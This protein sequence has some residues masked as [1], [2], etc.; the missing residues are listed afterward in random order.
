MYNW[1]HIDEEAMKKENPEKYRLW[2]IAAI[3]EVD[4]IDEKLDR[5]EVKAAWP[6]IKDQIDPWTRRAI[7]YILW[8]TTSS[9]PLD[10]NF[11]NK[12][13]K[14]RCPACHAGFDSMKAFLS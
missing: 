6:K 10:I 1:S 3:I 9:L 2:R 14:Y 5:E 8:G 7:E 12:P 13:A 4:C 11:W